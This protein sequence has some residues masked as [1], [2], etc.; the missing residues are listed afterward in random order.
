V[1]FNIRPVLLENAYSR[2]FGGVFGA[3]IVVARN[4]LQFHP[5]IKCNN[6]G[7]TSNGS[8]SVKIGSPVWPREVSKNCGHKKKK[9]LKPRESDILPMCRD[10]STGAIV[11]N[12]GLLGYIADVITHAQ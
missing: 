6:L 8:N 5:S 9:K 11:L 3:K 2:P 4:V 10:A 1:S 7:L 12:F